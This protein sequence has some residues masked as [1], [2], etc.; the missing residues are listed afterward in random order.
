VGGRKTLIVRT[1]Q[2]L[3]LRVSKTIKWGQFSLVPGAGSL[4]FWNYQKVFGFR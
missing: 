2:N 1:K 4:I 3:E